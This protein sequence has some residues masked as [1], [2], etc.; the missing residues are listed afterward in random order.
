[1]DRERLKALAQE[2][3]EISRAGRYTLGDR[4]IPLDRKSVV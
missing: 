2:T 3:L 1:M 4:V